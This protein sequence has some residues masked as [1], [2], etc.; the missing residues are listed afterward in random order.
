MYAVTANLAHGLYH[1]VTVVDYNLFI[2]FFYI[3]DV[4]NPACT[5]LQKMETHSCPVI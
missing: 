1:D 3:G 4:K 2:I 5:R